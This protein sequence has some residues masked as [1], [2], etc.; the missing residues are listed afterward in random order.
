[1]MRVLFFGTSPFAVPSLEALLH[2]SH[3]V[4][5]IV[6]QQDKLAG[7]GRKLTSPPVAVMAREKGIP[8]YQP[9]SLKD[10]SLWTPWQKMRP[11]C[12]VVVA[13][14]NFL[15]KALMA[16]PPK[17]CVNL[18][19]SLLPKYRGAAPINWAILNGDTVTGVTTMYIGNAMDAGDI[20]L[21]CEVPIDPNETASDLA[22]RLAPIGAELLVKTLDRLAAGSLAATPQDEAR[23][24]LAPALK[25]E[26]GL[27]NWKRPSAELINHIRGMQ[28]WPNAYTHLQSAQLTVFLAELLDEP[29]DATPGT[30][31]KL[32][33]AIHIATGDHRQLCLTDV[34]LAGTRR[35]P[36]SDFLRGHRLEPGIVLT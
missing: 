21:Q 11:E 5:G 30:I 34:Q 19:P 26:D 29:T 12:F 1:M 23:V 36:S 4:T 8:L 35:M 33:R 3:E 10:Q 6:T 13:Y 28:P 22:D 27:I 25:K 16:L 2:S 20:L 9:E 14:G 17:R 7:R 18:H 24:V 32:T 15:P 31:V